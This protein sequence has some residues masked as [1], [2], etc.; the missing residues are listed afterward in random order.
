MAGGLVLTFHTE[1]GMG[2]GVSSGGWDE[3]AQAQDSA[4]SCPGP[5]GCS[6]VALLS[7]Q[8]L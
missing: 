1:T 7:S 2:S 6:S 5:A 8:S 3:G 4:F